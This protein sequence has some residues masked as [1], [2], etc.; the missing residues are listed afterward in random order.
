[1]ADV[2]VLGAA[3]TIGKAIVRD[4]L[5]QGVEVMATDIDCERLQELRHWI[6]LDFP[7]STLDVVDQEATRQIL[8]KAKVC[9]NATNYTFNLHVMHACAAAGAHLL[10]LGGLY[11]MTKEQL[12]LDKKMRD[13]GVLSIVGMGS[14]PGASNIFARYGVDSLDTAEE[15]HIRFG[16]TTSGLTFPFAIDTIFDEATKSAVVYIDGKL[17]EIPPLSDEEYTVF[18]KIIGIQKT[19]AILHSELATLPQSFPDVQYITYKDSW[20]PQTIEK[21]RALEKMG[22]TQTE[23]LKIK[24]HSI[25]PRRQIVSLLG[26]TLKDEK[27][28]WGLDELLVEVKGIRSGKRTNI[29]VEMLSGWQK[30]WDTGPTA[31]A[32]AI[33]ASIAAIMLLN[34]EIKEL[35]VKP[36]EQC[37]NPQKFMAYLLQKN[38]KLFITSSETE[39][40]GFFQVSNQL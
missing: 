5:E 25:I 21:I 14:D 33:P 39:E 27:P 8:S 31:Y 32:T 23:P 40:K 12:K 37:I 30:N 19:Y 10:D 18:H 36:P 35:G 2:V 13:A 15:I 7:V 38:V 20:D 28:I 3:G 4:L 26:Q 11:N 1:M 34:G 24:D 16:S 29:K 22:L 6:R 9:V 17:K